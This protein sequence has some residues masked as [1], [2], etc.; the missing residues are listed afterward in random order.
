M[1]KVT[2]NKKELLE[3]IVENRT[4]HIQEYNEVVKE[5]QVTAQLVLEEK[6]KE[7]EKE[8]YRLAKEVAE[9]PIPITAEV[10]VSLTP[11]IS[12]EKEYNE[13]IMLFQMEINENVELDSNE[14]SQYV[15]DNWKW[16]Q[17]LKN[18]RTFYAVEQAKFKK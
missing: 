1:R 15:M 2:L 17:D 7:V 8:F 5:Y 14:F 3:K 6:F 13:I 4:K 11:P 18:T 16:Q 9:K 12:H 10:N